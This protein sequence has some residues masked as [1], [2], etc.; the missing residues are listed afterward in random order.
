MNFV[1]QL[2]DLMIKPKD[3]STSNEPDIVCPASPGLI[4]LLDTA[5][6]KAYEGQL[7]STTASANAAL[8]AFIALRSEA[9]K[10]SHA[11]NHATLK[12]T[13]SSSSATLHSK[14]QQKQNQIEYTKIITLETFAQFCID[15]ANEA[16]TQLT[17]DKI[18]TSAN[19]PI[20]TGNAAP[21][22]LSNPEIDERVRSSQDNAW[23]EVALRLSSSQQHE[24]RKK[25]CWESTKLYCPDY[26]WADEA[27]SQCQRLV[28]TMTK[29]D[30]VQAMTAVLDQHVLPEC[31]GK[32]REHMMSIYENIMTLLQNN[33]PLRLHQFHQGIESD[34][35]VS[36]RLYLV[37]TEY[38]GP[39]RSFL[40]AHEYIK[41]IPEISLVME[42][43]RL[44]ESDPKMLKEKRIKANQKIENCLRNEDLVMAVR[45]E[46]NS[47]VFEMNMAKMLLPF[48]EVA[49]LLMDGRLFA[50]VVEVPDLLE[51]N[52]VL[53]MQ[54]LLR[55]LKRI[56]CKKSEGR[57]SSGIRPLLLDLQGI[58]RDPS[59]P[60]VDISDPFVG[61]S[62][63][64]PE[65][66]PL[67]NDRHVHS[68]SAQEEAMA[69]N[70]Q[71]L[72][73]QLQVIYEIGK[74]NKFSVEKKEI[75]S[76]PAAIK[77]CAGFDGATFTK[78]YFDWYDCSKRQGR[79]SSSMDE[80]LETMHLAEIEGS[81]TMAP[82]N[83]L[84]AYCNSI[85]L[86]EI[87]RQRK[88]DILQEMVMEICLREMDFVINLILPEKDAILVLPDIKAALGLFD[89]ALEF[90]SE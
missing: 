53:R 90:D 36:K 13:V 4:T 24:L 23:E 62:E 66:L 88:F 68:T 42:Y 17:T 30:T 76:L 27:M 40:E 37:K 75:E 78:T 79:F 34:I 28:R 12:S 89:A 8:H 52:E 47:E 19:L 29:H 71:S 61:A 73:S 58:P 87:D 41:K 31:V 74:A 69:L 54:E 20:E 55:R 22:G 65:T 14:Q 84:S 49:R 6:Y 46:E 1:A 25:D 82:R 3:P 81:I 51:G 35:V 32:S 43:I 16:I 67:I 15:C 85:E 38:R 2:F 33:L 7:T 57:S 83:A 10:M 72:C 11:C 77:T 50:G 9:K 21:A 18:A 5:L 80:L 64:A 86:L 70:V 26:V 59:S 44:H 56:L 63:K 60:V 45:A 48:C 39:F